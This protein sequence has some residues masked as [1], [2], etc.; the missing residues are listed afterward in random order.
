MNKDNSPDN[1]KTQFYSNINNSQKT[2]IY[3]EDKQK[4]NKTET[5][6]DEKYQCTDKTKEH[7][8]GKGDIVELN[9]IKYTVIGIISEENSTGEAVIYKIRD[10]KNKIFALK[11]YYLF[12]D[13]KEEPNPEAL[14]RI[15][16]IKDPNIL[17]LYNF[18]IRKLKYR[19]KF[20]YEICDFAKGG[21][22]L[23]VTDLKKK[24]TPEF[25]K[26]NVIPEIYKGIKRL[27][28]NQIFHCDLRPENVFYLDEKQTDLIIGDYGSAKTFEET[29]DKSLRRTST[30]K[31]SDF[32]LPPEQARG[33]ISPKNDYYSFGMILLHL[34]YSELFEG[35]EVY[36]NFNKIIERQF[37]GHKIINFNDEFNRINTLIEGLT[38]HDHNARWG[39]KEVEKW[40]IG[41]KIKVLYPNKSN[42][43]PI[44]LKDFTNISTVNDLVDCIKDN[45]QWYYYLIEDS[46]VYNQLFIWFSQQYGGQTTGIFKN[47]ID[48]YK[49]ND[50]EEYV[51]EAILRYFNP[52]RPITIDMQ[53]Y[54]FFSE[55]N[56]NVFVDLFFR[57][58]DDMWKITDIEKIRYYF[59]Q[60]EFCLRQLQEVSINE[61]NF[62]IT[63]VLDNISAIIKPKRD[64]S[65]FQAV[66]YPEI[67]DIKLLDLFYAF[68]AKRVFKVDN[69]NSCHTIDEVG[70]Y[71]AENNPMFNNK[72]IKM[73]KYKFFSTMNRGDLIK[74][75]YK[76]TLFKIFESQVTTNIEFCELERQNQSDNFLISY[77]LEKS[78]I[79]NNMNINDTSKYELKISKS[80]LEKLT[81]KDE[82]E[83]GK[84]Q[85]EKLIKKQMRN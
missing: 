57:Q 37:T 47:M 46:K 20:C 60:F 59:F 29:S 16:K 64:F 72:Y 76:Q 66:L 51:Q 42:V 21:D 78:L 83:I 2:Q 39:E 52:R 68:N 14:K 19:N 38:L 1:N 35:E 28:K 10:Q 63:T 12:R 74:L 53:T 4:N 82:M 45:D 18:G 54:K 70:T 7:N 22:L 11:L 73:E 34:L 69:E 33:L 55:E 3:S 80:D 23:S 65:N 17:K 40:I 15:K 24:Y 71:F 62:Q 67:D 25:L 6:E 48:Y 49:V 79:I 75:K 13:L 84:S 32:Y 50:P 5:Y 61:L 58:L 27:H 26:S 9:K 36:A 85:L 30:V 81:S 56:L 44:I 43:Q 31:G 41:K 8:L 77:T